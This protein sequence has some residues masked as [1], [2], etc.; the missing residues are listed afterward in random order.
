MRKIVLLLIL[1]F[2]LPI[3]IF[4][5]NG[6]S[7]EIVRGLDNITLKSKI[8]S[9]TTRL[10][11]MLN[12]AQAKDKKSLNFNGIN[13]SDEARQTI[14]QLWNYQHMRV[15]QDVEDEEPYI[16][17]TCLKFGRQGWQVRGIPM[18]LYPIDGKNSTLQNEYTEICINYDGTGRIVDF[19]VT[20]SKQQYGAILKNAKSVEDEYN[21]MILAHWMEQL[22]TAYNQRNT[23]FFE[24]VFS[25]DALVI[26]GVR[27][28]RREKTDARLKDQAVF[29]YSQSTKKQYIDKLKKIFNPKVNPSINIVFGDDAVYRRHGGNPRYYMVDVTQHWNTTS[30][31]DVGHLFVIWDFK[32]PDS[33]QILVRVWQHPDDQKKFTAK[34][35]RLPN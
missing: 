13:I 17:E 5:Q 29:E 11:T 26:T 19:N 8:E 33:P 32:N 25:D 9:Q 28:F 27:K 22:A 30:Y 35:F 10:L 7:F 34:D 16:G 3:S 24:D 31:S 2:V 15:W 23:K 12:E 6:V 14:L 1:A 18:H 21:R 20:M 4:A